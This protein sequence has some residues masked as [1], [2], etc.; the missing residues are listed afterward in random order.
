MKIRNILTTIT[1]LGSVLVASAATAQDMQQIA[2]IKPAMPVVVDEFSPT[3]RWWHIHYPA[4]LTPQL[5]W[6]RASDG[7]ANFDTYTNET[8][9]PLTQ[10][11]A[12][13]V[14][15]LLGS[16]LESVG[17]D[18]YVIYVQT[19][20][21]IDKR[22]FDAKF[23]STLRRELQRDAY[24]TAYEDLPQEQSENTMRPMTVFLGHQ[25]VD[26]A[27]AQTRAYNY[28]NNERNR[29]MEHFREM[30]ELQINLTKAHLGPM[31][32]WGTSDYST[33]NT[34]MASEWLVKHVRT[35]IGVDDVWVRDG[36]L[37]VDC[38]KAFT[39]AEVRKNVASIIIEARHKFGHK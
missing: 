34:P 7:R 37:Y 27:G 33:G 19:K 4:G 1:L 8:P 22:D 36:I 18:R 23:I 16:N 21:P 14:L 15:K 29:Y 31:P 28:A 5:A 26:L 17:F 35:G 3:N 12:D 25:A 24:I 20:T 30:W 11:L 6:F 13:A 2:P 32:D 9:T 38:D 10:R 39:K